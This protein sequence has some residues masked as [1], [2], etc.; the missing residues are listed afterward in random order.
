MYCPMDLGHLVA[1]ENMGFVSAS[2]TYQLKAAVPTCDSTKHLF[3]L[4]F[5]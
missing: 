4:G 3:S 1:L 5:V 2:D